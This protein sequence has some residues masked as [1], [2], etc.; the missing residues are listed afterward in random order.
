MNKI[1]PVPS[2]ILLLLCAMFG[3]LMPL[4]AQDT[5]T[6][7]PIIDY[8]LDVN[9]P[10]YVPPAPA[11][12]QGEVLSNSD[13]SL[14]FGDSVP[15]VA[16]AAITYATSI[17]ESHLVSAVPVRV[18][19]VWEDLEE[20]NILASA[21]PSTLYRDFEG[22]VGEE[23]WYPVA[24]AEAIVGENLNGARPDIN[25]TV[26]SRANWYY[27]TDGMVPFN[28]IDLVSVALHELGHGLGFLSSADTAGLIQ[29]QL[30]FGDFPIV[31]DLYLETLSGVDLTDV[32]NFPNPSDVLLEAFTG[33]GLYF[34][35]PIPVRVNGQRPRLF[36]PGQFDIGSSISHLDE[37]IYPAGSPNS[38]MT[39]F[40]A[41]REAVHQPG[42]V[43]LSIMEQ[44]GWTVEYM[45]TPVREVVVGEVKVYPNPASG[46][47]FIDRPAELQPG[48]WNLRI[49][50][51]QGRTV[52]QLEVDESL[53]DVSVSDLAPGWYTVLLSNG[54]K[55]WRAPL[56][57]A[58]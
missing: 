29:G 52:R 39:P 14:T 6:C 11:F 46:H 42:D 43:T 56:V 36:A 27:G 5:L 1:Y 49:A 17:W 33:N 54:E 2:H 7:P 19:V 23:V 30:N 20:P 25:I 21:G 55:V 53:P 48:R 35:G 3:M 18:N 22:S 58:R 16:Q 57:I 34:G 24:L 26:N 38:L 40:L 37:T 9:L 41:R 12:L 51:G 8:L 50:D 10:A 4:R 32:L 47:F 28:K 45:V 31:F 44:M 15:A 13:M